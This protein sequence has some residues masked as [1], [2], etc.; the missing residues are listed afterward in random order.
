VLLTCILANIVHMSFL[1]MSTLCYYMLFLYIGLKKV[2]SIQFGEK[3]CP[4]V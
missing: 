4:F 3:L 2:L 1:Y